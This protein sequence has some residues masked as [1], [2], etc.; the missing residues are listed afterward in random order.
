MYWDGLPYFGPGAALAYPRMLTKA[1]PSHRNWREKQSVVGEPLQCVCRCLPF[2]AVQNN[3]EFAPGMG[4][5]H[6]ATSTRSSA[7]RGELVRLSKRRT[8]TEQDWHSR[9]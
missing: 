3:T 9:R 4:I 5:E 7:S 2:S 6:L 8:A 1:G